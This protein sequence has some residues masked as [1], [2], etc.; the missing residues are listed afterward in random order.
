MTLTRW[1]WVV[2]WLLVLIATVVC[3]VPGHEIPKAFEF[4]DKLSHIIGHGGL[5]AYFT[6]LMP[7]RAWWKIFLYLLLFGVVIELAQYNM[8]VG[9]EGDPRDVLANSAGALVG[10]LAGYLG[11]ARWPELVAAKLGRGGVAS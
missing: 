6:G 11:V 3:L 10:L 1:E 8:H 7:R 9:R 5:A 4:N 2:G